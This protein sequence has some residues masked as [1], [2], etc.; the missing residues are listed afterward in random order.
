M[1][2]IALPLDPPPAAPS[3]TEAGLVHGATH[4]LALWALQFTPRVAW[5]EEALVMEVAASL[6]LFGGAAALQARVDAEAPPLGAGRA[7]R[8]PT[9]LAALALARA[10]RPDGLGQPLPRLLDPLPL[11]TLSAVAAHQAT[12]ARL[13]CRTLGDVRRLP[14]GGLARRFGAALLLGLDQAYGLH[15]EAHDWLTVPEHFA[16]RLE[17]P[18]RVEHTAALLGAVQHL[19]PLL[20]DWLAARQAGVVALTL[21]WRHDA[22]R[23]RAVGAAGALA[24]RTAAPTRDTRHLDRLLAEHLARTTLQ[25]PVGEIELVADEVQPLQPDS[26]DLLPDP[27]RSAASLR[28]ALERIAARLGP[29][30]VS[31]P[32]RQE[33]HRPEWMQ[34]WQPATEPL[35]RPSRR[36]AVTLP[37][38]TWV[39]HE[40]VALVV[41]HHRPL[42]QGPLQL[43]IGPQRIEG[44]W[45]HRSAAD[46]AAPAQMHHVQRDYWV[47]LS[48]QAGALWIYQ[49]RLGRDRAAWFLHGHYA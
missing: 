14:R 28:E 12:L 33:D 39:L 24:L 21:H 19:W 34:A 10:G 41:R 22:L 20:R 16:V 11:D 27:S 2:W 46:G 40:P 35:P 32:V 37:Q 18:G 45:W 13:G 42:Y 23:A 15:P 29:Q 47:A 25:A 1:H 48:E 5:L 17:L 7:S 6:R 38:P 31:R 3:P 30:R 43:L 26:G 49:E 4:G 44:G 9:S 8:A 36:R